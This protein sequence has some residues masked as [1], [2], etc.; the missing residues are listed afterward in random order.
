MARTNPSPNW[1]KEFRALRAA[2]E[3]VAIVG[4]LVVRNH[5]NDF[6]IVVSTQA[7]GP[8]RLVKHLLQVDGMNIRDL[9]LGS[10]GWKL[11]I[12]VNV[13][14]RHHP[15][16]AAEHLLRSSRVRSVHVMTTAYKGLFTGWFGALC[17]RRMPADPINDASPTLQ[18]MAK[19]SHGQPAYTD[20]AVLLM[21]AQDVRTTCDH[22]KAWLAT[23]GFYRSL[24]KAAKT[25]DRAAWIGGARVTFTGVEQQLVASVVPCRRSDVLAVARLTQRERNLVQMVGAGTPHAIIANQLS[26]SVLEIRDELNRLEHN[27]IPGGI[28]GLLRLVEEGWYSASS[29]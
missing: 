23:S 25:P 13:T 8:P 6:P 12:G 3:L 29:P 19:N 9:G 22:G 7:V 28:P 1:N 15:L 21:T 2:G 11:N 27:R 24:R 10:T 4:G 18:S 17:K 16:T 26:C 20:P 5:M 14:E